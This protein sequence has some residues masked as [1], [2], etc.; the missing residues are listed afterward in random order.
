MVVRVAKVSRVPQAFKQDN[1]VLRSLV[2]PVVPMVHV[3]PLDYA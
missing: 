2:I 1:N 3:L